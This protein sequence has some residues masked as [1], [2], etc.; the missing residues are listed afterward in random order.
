VNG[1][2]GARVV[3]VDDEFNE[4]MPMIK[5]FS[6]A[7]VPTAY[8]NGT[9]Q[10]ELPSP[11][12]RLHGVRL[13]ILDMDLGVG[14]SP[15]NKASTLVQVLGKIIAPKNGPYGVLI[16]TNH[17]DL[18]SLALKYISERSEAPRPVFVAKMHKADF[19]SGLPK[20]GSPP[21]FALAR[22]SR[23]LRAEL[24]E[25]SPLE[26]LQV[27]EALCFRAAT[28]VTNQLGEVAAT[29]APDLAQW[30]K[31]WQDEAL[32]LLLAIGK[33]QA[34]KNLSAENCM[35]SI[36]LALTPLHGDRLDLLAEGTTVGLSTH[37]A[38]IMAAS[39][40]SQ[41][42]RKA[43]VNSMLHLGSDHLEQFSPGNAYVWGK[44]NKPTF[45]PAIGGILVGAAD[46]SSPKKERQN[47]DVLRSNARL[48][49]VEITPICDYAQGKMGLA[50][51]IAG[52]VLPA[53][54]G[55]SVRKAG[56]LKCFGPLYLPK[57]RVTASDSYNIYLD[58]RHVVSAE[59]ALVKTLTPIARVR[60]QL[61]ADIQLWAAYQASRQGVMLLE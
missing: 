50:R 26:C 16:W 15:E 46:V 37:V 42:D 13:A 58:A 33:A 9:T 28:N 3:V 59:L 17:P 6:R 44:S 5:A 19:F 36:F 8:F 24:V 60:S 14:G 35:L 2:G 56:Y 18:E 25:N 43:K 23:A 31:A 52:F 29:E 27:W 20:A 51:I 30:R 38:R 57:T 21:T 49:G 10:S 1:L 39:G 47:L 48:C 54:Y 32:P 41:V 22:L 53:G 61:L 7:G 4:A 45:L 55:K 12:R 34:G 11:T 40:T